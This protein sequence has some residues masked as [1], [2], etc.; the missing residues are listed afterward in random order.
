MAACRQLGRQ[1]LVVAVAEDFAARSAEQLL[2]RPVA[3]QVAAV[4]VL[5]H[6]AVGRP[7]DQCPEH[8]RQFVDAAVLPCGLA[9]QQ[10]VVLVPLQRQLDRQFQFAIVVRL[11][12]V[13]V[14]RRYAGAREALVVGVGSQVEQRHPLLFENHPRRLDTVDATGQDDVHQDQVGPFARRQRDGLAA[15]GHRADDAMAHGAEPQRQSA[16]NKWVI[17][18][19][20]DALAGGWSVAHATP[21]G[22]AVATSTRWRPRRLAS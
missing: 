19:D 14:R 1:Q 2:E 15:A 5:G 11:E 10:A 12:Q 7:F 8:R 16:G 13:G 21:P 6:D 9:T 3:E 22:P 20:Q 4:G 18:D 17:L